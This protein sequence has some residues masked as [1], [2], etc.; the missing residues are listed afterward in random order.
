[1]KKFVLGNG[2][3]GSAFAN[4]GYELID[5]NLF[6]ATRGTHHRWVLEYYLYDADVVVNAV[7]KTDTRWTEDSQNFDNLWKV[8]VEFPHRISKWC[9]RRGK[10]FVHLSTGDVYGNNFDLTET[11]EDTRKIDVGT[12]YRL[13]KYVSEKMCHPNDLI[14][15][16]RLPFDGR[17][18]PKNLLTKIPKF[19][20][21]YSYLNDYTYVP[22]LVAFT[23]LAIEK[24]LSGIYN[25]ASHEDG[26]LMFLLR[27]ILKLDQFMGEEYD[28]HNKESPYLIRELNDIH[29]HNIMNDDKLRKWFPQTPLE[30]AIKK[31]WNQLQAEQSHV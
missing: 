4:A 25:I 29:V 26:S 21:F 7:G 12:N 8:N 9:N 31:S 13:S 5:K 28:L 10:K 2:Y 17:N 24:N 19:T 23:D 6:D 1:M 15:R 22:D 16:L 11:T 30:E 14:L 27:N 20:K 3:I 18:H